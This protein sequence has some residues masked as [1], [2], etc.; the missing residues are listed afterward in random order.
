[1]ERI[2]DRFDKY[3]SLRGLNDNVVT[4]KLSFSVGLI[5]KSRKDGRDLSKSA[6]EA[7]LNFYTDIEPVWL[8][9][10]EGSMLKSVNAQNY[11]NGNSGTLTQISGARDITNR[12][13]TTTHTTTNHYSGCSEIDQQ[14]L[15]KALEEI[16]EQRKLV[17]KA[18]EQIDTLLEL[19]KAKMQI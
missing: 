8:L 5:G 14:A 10:G 18:Q 2:I 3:M 6:T 15:A 4:K 9:T 17:A 19:L 11:S 13:D 1:M 12:G 16:S 7:I